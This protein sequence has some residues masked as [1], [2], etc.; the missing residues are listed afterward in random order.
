MPIRRGLISLILKFALYQ[1][2]CW[3]LLDVVVSLL[4]FT[5]IMCPPPLQPKSQ[6]GTNISKHVVQAQRGFKKLLRL[7]DCFTV[8]HAPELASPRSAVHVQ[9][10]QW[11]TAC[12][13]HSC[14]VMKQS[15]LMSCALI[16]FK[17]FVWPKMVQHCAAHVRFV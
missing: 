1:T 5:L 2:D 13:H 4:A 9:S 6:R 17:T 16:H 11:R 8:S 10:H 3:N 15:V 12:S 14:D 7:I